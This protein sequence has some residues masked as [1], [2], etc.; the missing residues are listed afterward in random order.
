MGQQTPNI[1]AVVRIGELFKGGGNPSLPGSTDPIK[2]SCQKNYHM[3][4]TDGITNQTALPSTT[5]GNVD[6]IVP[7]LPQPLVVAPPIVAGAPWPNLYREN[8]AASMPNTLA[9]YTTHYW[10]TDMR[11]AM[12]NDVPI[13]KDPAPWQ[14]L[15][16]AALSL[17]T[18]GVLTADLAGRR[19]GADRHRHGE[20]ADALAQ[21]LEAGIE[22]RRRPV[23]RR[24]QCARTLRQRED[25]A[26]A[27]AAASRRSSSTSRA[28]QARTSARPS[29]TPTCRPATTSRTS[30]SSCRAGAATSR[31][32]ASTRPRAPRSRSSGTRRR[33]S[34]RR[35]RRPSRF[36]RPG[37]P[38]AASSR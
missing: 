18:E 26:A 38:S 9:D 28:R 3:L 23:A 6:D 2:L 34:P 11:P 31:R 37:T 32:S 24:R 29:P 21:L 13:G 19:R 35:P 22:R 25:F 33:S 7:P 12:P 17:G 27:G 1:D 20:V 8:T 36:R 14:H 15:N 10:V 30:P 16:F 4:F 5:V